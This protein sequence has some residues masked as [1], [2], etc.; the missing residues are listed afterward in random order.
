[1]PVRAFSIEDG[2]L[3][4]SAIRVARKKTYSDLDL[5]FT[6]R[7]DNDIYRKT[8]AAAVKQAVRNL[9]LTSYAERPF[10]PDFGGDLNSLLFNLDTEFDDEL[11]EEAIIEAVE[12]YEPRARVLD[13]KSS[14][15]GDL[16]SARVTVTFQ[17]IN[18]EQIET[19]EL[20]LTR[21][22]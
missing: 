12:T 4:S 14:I 10:M 17:V 22:R 6:K 5:T 20:D 9:L 11:S 21:L 18:T 8:D 7:P 13:V 3:N 19:V 2:N 16:N 15:V 1:M